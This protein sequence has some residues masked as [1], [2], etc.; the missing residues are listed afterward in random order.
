[1]FKEWL[2]QFNF[3]GLSILNFVIVCYM[4]YAW[5][6]KKYPNKTIAYAFLVWLGVNIIFYLLGVRYN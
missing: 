3:D 5:Y 1:M 4:G 6:K 2:S